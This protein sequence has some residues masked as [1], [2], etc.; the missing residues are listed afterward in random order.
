[1]LDF[2]YW[3]FYDHFSAH[4]P[5]T[6]TINLMRMRLAWKKRQKTLDTSKRLHQNKT[7]STGSAGKGLD[8]KR[9]HYWELQTRKWAGSSLPGGSW[10]VMKSI[11]N[12][13]TYHGTVGCRRFQSYS[14]SRPPPPEDNLLRTTLQAPPSRLLRHTGWVVPIITQI[15]HGYPF[16]RPPSRSRVYFSPFWELL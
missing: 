6:R 12:R 1:M 8:S 4:S 7:Q 16:T 2:I 13:T 9:C 11:P 15:L 14:C 3:M 5:L 10:E